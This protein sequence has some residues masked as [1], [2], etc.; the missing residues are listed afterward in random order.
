MSHFRL[1]RRA[2]LRGA[3]GVAIALPWL[4]VMQ[5]GRESKAATAP[6]SRFVAVYQPGGTILEQWRPT[7]SETDFELSPILAPFGAAPERLLVLDGIDMTSAVGEQYQAGMV[8]WLTGTRQGAAGEFARGPSIDQVIASRIQGGRSTKSLELAV[9]WGT[10]KS[11]GLV[12][13][14]NIVNYADNATFDPIAPRLDPA[15]VFEQLFGALPPGDSPELAW[16]QSI[17]DA[18]DRR[19]ERLLVRLG[20]DDRARLE[21]HM[22]QIRELEQRLANAPG[23]CA[24]PALVDTTGYDPNAGSLPDVTS[25]GICDNDACLSTDQMIPTVGRLMTDMLVMAMA[26]DLT[27]VGTLQWCDSEA[28]YTLPWLGL[29]EVHMY[30]QSDGGFQPAECAQIATWYSEQHNYLLNEMAS[31]DLGGHSL[32][33]ESVV[34]FGTELQHPAMHTKNNMPFLLAGGGGGLRT[35]RYLTYDHP[36]H[37]DLLVAL[38]NL[39]G[40]PATTF[41]DPDYVD[42]PLTNLT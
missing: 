1:S 16:D 36:S 2:L 3:G 28:K 40:D 21:R 10:G 15:L 31:V 32:L 18:L 35:G 39:F 13:P 12:H 23:R 7:G 37:N 20:A 42:G 17:L 24:P 14:I 9:R 4:E 22:T 38:L 27:A 34:F 8:A 30:Y 29:P 26:C 11:H 25:G 5:L 6:A 33:D 41:G 19:Y